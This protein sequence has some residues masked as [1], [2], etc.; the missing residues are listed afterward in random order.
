MDYER[1][2]IA[3]VVLLTPEKHGD[4]RGFLM[5]TFRQNEFEAVCG[6]YYFVQ[7]NHSRSGP[8][9]LRGLHYQRTHAQGKLVRVVAGEIFDVAVDV[10]AASLTFGQWV[11]CWLS[12]ANQRMLWVPPG[13]AHGFYVTGDGA[14]CLYKCTAYYAPDDEYCVRWDDPELAIDWPTGGHT[15][16]ISDRDSRGRAFANTPRVEE[17]TLGQFGKDGDRPG[18]NE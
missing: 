11:G 3:E 8:N 15:P 7:D 13:F 14:D 4:E 6:S 17:A 12:A 5:E 16:R 10:R 9:I 1:Q 18:A 2:S